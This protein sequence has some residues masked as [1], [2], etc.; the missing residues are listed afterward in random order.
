LPASGVF[1]GGIR[2]RCPVGEREFSTERRFVTFF[3]N[4]R[5]QVYTPPDPDG[6]AG[7][8]LFRINEVLRMGGYTTDDLS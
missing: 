4:P 5:L 8:Y 3:S 7:T 2:T 6:Y 1:S